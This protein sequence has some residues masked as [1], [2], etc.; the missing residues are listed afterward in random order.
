MTDVVYVVGRGSAW[1][2]NELRFSMRSLAKY[3]SGIG[4]V[5]IVG[6][7]PAFVTNV[8]PIPWPDRYPCKE[9]NIM[10]K[11]AAACGH[12][13]LTNQFLHVHDDH[14]AL[15]PVAAGEVPNFAGPVDLKGL[16]RSVDPGNTWRESVLNA[17]HALRMRG[18]TT[19]NFDIHTPILIDKD[20]YPETMDLYDWRGKPR[21]FVVKS[22]YGN[23]VG[24]QPTHLSDIKL[25]D[26][27]GLAELVRQ[28]KGRPWFSIGNGALSPWFKNLLGELYPMPSPW[29][30]NS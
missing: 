20:R 23:T 18:L 8:V 17:E 19:W 1:N 9:R 3:V 24:L 12:S 13:Q 29:E 27:Y 25:N 30:R 21:G 10:E 4:K 22:L 28:L 7:I 14:F 6:K 16:A 11:L 2:D 15:A 5:F 26:R